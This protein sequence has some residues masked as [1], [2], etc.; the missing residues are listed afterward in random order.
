MKQRVHAILTDYDGTLVSTA[1]AKNLET[2]IVPSKLEEILEKVCS[3]IPVCVIS[4]KDFE[5]LKNKA[6][7]ARVLS[8]M[9]GIETLV[10]RNHH[11]SPRTIEKRLLYADLQVLQL[12]SKPLEAIAEE[13]GSC[14]EFS[15]MLIERKHTSDGILAGL[16]ID[17]RHLSDDWSYYRRGITHFVSSMVANL[18]KP[19][20]PVDIYIQKYSEHPFVDIYSIECNKGVAFDT[21]ISELPYA[22]AHGKGTL[23]LGDSENDNPAFR[24][25]GISIGIRS[26]ARVNPKLDCSYFL[27]YEQLSSF[28]MKLRNNDYLFNDDELL[29]E[30]KK[31]E[32]YQNE[33]GQ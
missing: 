6:A 26:D 5:F 28:L 16:T 14:E 17:W 20:V 9:M 15:S 27:D 8:C 18:K 2:N 19:P 31:H 24:K 30:A 4:T 21:V 22:S 32:Q 11:G 7:F 23:Y 10:L 25:A 12:K 1:D 33:M 3:E 13:V 29:R